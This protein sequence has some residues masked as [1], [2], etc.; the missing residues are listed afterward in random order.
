MAAKAA[1]VLVVNNDVPDDI[2]ATARELVAAGVPLEKLYIEVRMVTNANTG[3][4]IFIGKIPYVGFTEAKAAQLAK[5][6]GEFVGI[7]KTQKAEFAGERIR[8]RFEVSDVAFAAMPPTPATAAPTAPGLAGMPTPSTGG[9]MAEWMIGMMMQAQRDAAQQNLDAQRRQ[10]E[11]T[12]AM[13]NTQRQTPQTGFGDKIMELLFAKALDKSPASDAIALMDA[14]DK[15]RKPTGDD[16]DDAEPA[17]PSMVGMVLKALTALAQA[18]ANQNATQ[19]PQADQ[20][21]QPA[22]IQQQPAPQLAGSTEPAPVVAFTAQP[23]ATPDA[24]VDPKTIDENQRLILFARRAVPALIDAATD[25]T[26]DVD[27]AA[28]M[29]ASIAKRCGLDPEKWKD[30]D[31]AEIVDSA[32]A[33]CPELATHRAFAVQAIDAMKAAYDE[34]DEEEDEPD[35]QD[36]K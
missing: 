14:L 28:M 30:T 8:W 16:A 1:Q 2:D 6:A 24:K 21:A 29:V 33:L 11:L 9:S 17:E 5:S 13:L 4:G 26:P 19:R 23:E 22:T 3:N 12:L 35:A 31:A 27:A 20:A 15:R 36:K 25:P 34:E 7:L 32:I 18:G 10:H